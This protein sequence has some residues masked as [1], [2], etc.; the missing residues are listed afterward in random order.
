MT[1]HAGSAIRSSS[2]AGELRFYDEATAW[3][4]IAGEDGRFYV[5]RARRLATP[6]L[7]AGVRVLFDPVVTPGGLR[8]TAVRRAA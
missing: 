3:G 2:L 1:E 8:A 5:L 4:V 6:P 7:S